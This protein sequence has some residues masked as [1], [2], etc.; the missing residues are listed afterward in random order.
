M[1]QLHSQLQKDT[2]LFGRFELCQLM[3]MNDAN[4]PWFI[5]VPERENVREIHE[6]N[7]ADRRQLWEESAQLSRALTECFRPDKLNIAALGNQVPQLHIHHIVRYTHD[8][9]W[10]Q[11]VWGKVPPR[12]YYSAEIVKLKTTLLPKLGADFHPE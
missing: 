1:F 12:P 9:A 8:A 4:Y 5:L 10:P 6:L 7:D 3:L 2:L 11:P